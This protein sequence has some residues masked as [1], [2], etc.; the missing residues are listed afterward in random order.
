MKKLVLDL[1]HGGIDQGA[2]GINISEAAAI[3]MIGNRI[4]R[5]L[6]DKYSVEVILTRL[7]N[8]TKP[9]LAERAQLAKDV[10][11]DAFVSIHFNKYNTTAYGFESFRQL[12]TT[13]QSIDY[14][15]QSAIHQKVLPVLG[16]YNV[17]DR[18][19]KTDDFQVL[20]DLQGS[21]IPAVLLE[22]CFLDNATDIEH[23][24]GEYGIDYE[25]AVTEGI[26]QF[27]Q[28]PTL[29]SI[30]ES[31]QTKTIDFV[32]KVRGDGDINRIIKY[33]GSFADIVAP[34]ELTAEVGGGYSGAAAVGGT[35]CF[36]ETAVA[37]RR[38]QFD[39]E[40][41]I[42]SIAPISK[43]TKIEF[44]QKAA[45]TSSNPINA[46]QKMYAWN[47][48][49]KAWTN[50]VVKNNENIGLYYSVVLAKN[51]ADYVDETGTIRFALV[52]LE[53]SAADMPIRVETDHAL[54]SVDFI[55]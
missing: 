45:N 48:K 46:Q 42:N 33:T 35:T 34:T 27:L 11:A 52:S 14:A 55:G 3:S 54:L 2:A 20:R 10:L 4:K 51:L 1:G 7:D 6:I 53:Q 8:S 25:I 39:F 5:R 28:L 49:R 47:V 32:G 19:M 23:L 41:N 43:V 40:F 29:A 30:P 24:L 16:T 44:K 38:V 18:G 12:G 21:G 36:Y 9:E 50:G 17:R 15:L 13:E 26:A 22:G 37:G 31:K